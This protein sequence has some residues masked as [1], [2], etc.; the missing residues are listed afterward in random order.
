MYRGFNLQLVAPFQLDA[1]V[2]NGASLHNKNRN[3]IRQTLGNFISP[4]GAVDGSKLREY[5]FPLLEADV[6]ISHAHTDTKQ[7]IALSGWLS[8]MGVTS[9]V[10]SSVWGYAADL[11]KLIDN[12]HC[13]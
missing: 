3:Y 12:D 9:F 7:A 8:E 11:Q 1:G 2:M 4:T 5:W 6:F 10:D 13:R